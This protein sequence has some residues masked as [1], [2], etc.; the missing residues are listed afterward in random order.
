[1][2]SITASNTHIDNSYQTK[3]PVAI[4]SQVLT[5]RAFCRV[6]DATLLTRSVRSLTDEWCAHNFLYYLHIARGRTADVDLDEAKWHTEIG[7]FILAAIYKL[8][9]TIL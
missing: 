5:L 7:Y 8:I 2:T 6:R 9:Y 3:S 1:M 4:K